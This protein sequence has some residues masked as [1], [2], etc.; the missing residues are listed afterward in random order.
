VARRSKPK[1]GG[2]NRNHRCGSSDPIFKLRP[3][4]M[5]LAWRC[6]NSAFLCR[7]K[8]L[9]SSTRP[10]SK[11]Q[12]RRLSADSVSSTLIYPRMNSARQSATGLRK[13]QSF[14]RHLRQPRAIVYFAKNTR[15]RRQFSASAAL[16]DPRH[17]QHYGRAI[18]WGGSPFL[19]RRGAGVFGPQPVG[20]CC[21][22]DDAPATR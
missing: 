18:E 13:I 19:A 16:R 8:S 21:D 10:S 20:T 6:A 5:G 17:R 1:N 12:V 4:Y 15:P 11:C 7:P 2:R 9:I 14:S 22:H 3:T